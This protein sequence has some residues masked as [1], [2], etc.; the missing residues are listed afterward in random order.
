MTDI[1][2]QKNERQIANAPVKSKERHPHAQ[3]QG[4]LFPR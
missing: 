1:N 4:L 2:K 3:S